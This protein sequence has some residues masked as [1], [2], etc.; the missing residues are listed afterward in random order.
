MFATVGMTSPATRPFWVSVEGPEGVGKT[1]L[2]RRLASRLASCQLLVEL[3]DAEGEQVPTQVIAALASAGDRFLR[4]GHPLTETF[5]LLA[6]KT[7]ERELVQRMSSPPQIVLEDRGLDTVAIYQ[8]AILAGS[9][10]D[11]DA[12]WSLAEHVFTT[13][14]PWCP[15]P[16]LTVLLIEDL[17][18]CA[19][20][21]TMREG[22]PFT[23]GQLALVERATRL[24][25]RLAEQQPDRVRTIDRSGHTESQVLDELDTLIRQAASERGR[26]PHATAS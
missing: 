14:A 8:A 11:D 19:A 23:T 24:Y 15:L 1:H 13:A 12:V 18:V 22:T 4:T 5:A 10:S 17:D 3:T 25:R 26:R 16:D 21:W 2:A 9:D 20:R 7:R 6:L